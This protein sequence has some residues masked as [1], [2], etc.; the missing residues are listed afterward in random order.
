VQL[1]FLCL[2]NTLMYKPKIILTTAVCVLMSFIAVLNT[3]CSKSNEN[4]CFDEKLYI[5][6]QNWACL[7][8]CPDG[9]IIGCNGK[10]YCN[11]CYAAKEGIRPH[12]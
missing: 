12:K 1:L 2:K 10:G 7:N 9:G 5:E 8:S 6:A 4:Y 11:G 3:S